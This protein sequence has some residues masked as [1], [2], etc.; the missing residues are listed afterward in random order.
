MRRN[1]QLLWYCC[2]WE[3][4]KKDKKTTL[5]IWWRENLIMA[6]CPPILIR[7]VVKVYYVSNNFIYLKEKE[8][9][10]IFLKLIFILTF[11]IL[12]YSFPCVTFFTRNCL[13]SH[14][15]LNVE[16]IGLISISASLWLLNDLLGW[17]GMKES[18]LWLGEP[19]ITRAKKAS[20]HA[21]MQFTPA[22]LLIE[23]MAGSG[24][25]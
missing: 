18:I 13:I 7:V 8:R 11:G 14:I 25:K 4:G 9:Y 19:I 23:E 17:Q 24:F 15:L 21:L 16:I 3:K 22:S 20:S 5:L 12:C 1:G 6:N 10:W 2:N